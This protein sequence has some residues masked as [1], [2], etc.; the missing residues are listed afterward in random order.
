MIKIDV[1]LLAAARRYSQVLKELTRLTDTREAYEGHEEEFELL[2]DEVAHLLDFCIHYLAGTIH[3]FDDLGQENKK[4][5]L[6]S[7]AKEIAQL[8]KDG[9]LCEGHNK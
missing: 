4:A 8:E 3:T 7:I 2:N 9:H 6:K 5:V 1:H